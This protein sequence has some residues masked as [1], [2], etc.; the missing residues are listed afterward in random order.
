MTMISDFIDN[1]VCLIHLIYAV[2][3]DW[4][5]L[6][7]AP[8]IAPTD[9]CPQFGPGGFVLLILLVFIGIWGRGWGGGELTQRK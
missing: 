1:S 4:Q 5:V 8:G 2:T 3:F 6:F 7:D 9:Y